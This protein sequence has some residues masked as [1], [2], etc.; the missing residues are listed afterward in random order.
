VVYASTDKMDEDDKIFGKFVLIEKVKS[1]GMAEVYKAK[2]VG[3]TGISKIVGLKRILPEH[4]G[5]ENFVEMFKNE[6][7]AALNLTHSNIAQLYEFGEEGEHFFIAMEFVDGY[8]L[9]TILNQCREST[10]RFSVE[11]AVY[12]TSQIARGLDYAH[13]FVDK[14]THLPLNIIHRDISPGNIMLNRSGEVKIIDFGVCKST[15]RN[16]DTGTGIVKGKL[17]YLSPEQAR[18]QNIDRRTDIFSLGLVFWE[19]LF[20]KK[21]FQGK[22]EI[23]LLNRIQ[24]FDPQSIRD[25]ISSFDPELQNI[26]LR[27][28]EG[29]RSERYQSAGDLYND[30]HHLLGDMNP[31]FSTQKMVAKIFGLF[32]AKEFSTGSNPNFKQMVVPLGEDIQTQHLYNS[33]TPSHKKR[34]KVPQIYSYDEPMMKRPSPFLVIVLVLILILFGFSL[35]KTSFLNVAVDTY[36]PKVEPPSQ[37]SVVNRY[38]ASTVPPKTMEVRVT[39]NPPYSDVELEGRSWGRTPARL[40][41]PEKNFVKIVLRHKGYVTYTLTRSFTK[42][43]AFNVTLLKENKRRIPA[44][45]RKN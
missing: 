14:M 37:V 6:A 2:A 39:S 38:V 33:R 43:E 16:E 40:F 42:S 25:R 4:L 8:D 7:R 44:G 19:L 24:N 23:V 21:L 1:G 18:G 36:L 26:L 34:S 31:K 29:D 27:C 3:T 20:H 28:L 10:T 9:R 30:L 17:T 32:S 13:S 22:D 15:A 41:V 11:E 35:G 5:D 45:W 12:I